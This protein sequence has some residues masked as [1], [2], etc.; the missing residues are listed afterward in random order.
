MSTNRYDD[1][2]QYADQFQA[3]FAKESDRASVIIAVAMLDQALE[4]LLKRRLV[5]TPVAHDSFIEGAYVPL[6]TLSS[7]IDLCFRMGLISSQFSR[8]LHLIR[9]IRNEFAHN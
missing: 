3:E 2:A 4:A 9:R 5:P 6:S 1:V 8:D 7:R